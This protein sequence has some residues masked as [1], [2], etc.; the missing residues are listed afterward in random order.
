MPICH[1]MACLRKVLLWYMLFFLQQ[2]L[3]AGDCSAEPGY[4]GSGH[5]VPGSNPG[6]QV[7]SDSCAI[8]CGQVKGCAFWTFDLGS[9]YCWLKTSDTVKGDNSETINFLWGGPCKR[10]LVPSPPPPPSPDTEG[11]HTDN[12]SARGPNEKDKKTDSFPIGLLI[13][14]ILLVLGTLC[15][16]G[17][18]IYYCCCRTGNSGTGSSERTRKESSL[19]L[20]PSRMGQR[21]NQQSPS[22]Q[23]SQDY[24][25]TR[26]SSFLYD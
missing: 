15:W 19:W 22:A 6:V 2:T 17:C 8:Q 21:N 11:S 23:E 3:D 1:R 4:L 13:G 9:K 10:T 16:L 5:N 24:E 25:N 14:I 7:D 20:A 26:Q 18:C 12:D